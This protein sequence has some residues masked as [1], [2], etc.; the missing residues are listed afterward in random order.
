M[1]NVIGAPCDA[2]IYGAALASVTNP[3]LLYKDYA[4]LVVEL[5]EAVIR[6]MASLVGYDAEQATGVFTAGGTFCNMYGYLFGICKNL[7]DS[8]RHGIN[9]GQDYRFINSKGGHYSNITNL[10]VLGADV[11]RNSFASSSRMTTQWT[12]RILKINLSLACGWTVLSRQ[13]C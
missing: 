9:S 8:L 6:Q 7:P 1:E 10:A 3:N 13:C 2:G 11:S 4:G 12:W 5:E